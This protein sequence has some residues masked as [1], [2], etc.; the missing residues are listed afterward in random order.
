[1]SGQWPGPRLTPT[2][3]NANMPRCRGPSLVVIVFLYRGLANACSGASM[4]CAYLSVR[5]AAALI[6]AAVC[7]FGAHAQ[8]QRLPVVGYLSFTSPDERPTLVAAFRQ[9]LQ[10]AGFIVGQNVAIEY[11]SAGGKSDRL[12]ALAAELAKIPAAVIAATGGE[13]VA[14]AAKAATSQIPIVFTSS[15][16]VVKG[17]LVASLNRPGGN[18][19]GVSLLGYELDSKRLQLLRELLPRSSTIGVLMDANNPVITATLPQMKTAA[20]ANGQ[21]LVVLD[22]RTE[23]DID[24]AFASL[25]SKGVDALL[26]TTNPFYEGRRDDIVALAKRHSVP[27]LYP[28]REYSVA[29]GLISYGTSFTESYR[30]AGLYV[31]RILK[32]EKPADLP[33]VQATKFELLVNITTAK[34]LGLIVPPS[35]LV[36]ADEVIE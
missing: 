31:G 22:A 19:T 34:S 20:D 2:V 3:T 12:P 32:G 15:S 21:R 6:S 7:S 10:Q 5:A 9:G 23:V 28:W 16:D 35:I 11:R 30:Q 36:S 1:M 29:G 27:V 33:V 26:V 14:R 18:V 8:Q 4:R 25:R 17:G 13:A 24:A